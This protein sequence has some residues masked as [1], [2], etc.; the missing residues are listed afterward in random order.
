MRLG[1][2]IVALLG[3]VGCAAMHDAA[4]SDTE[5]FIDMD[6]PPGN[7]SAG[8][9][10]MPCPSP[11]DTGVPEGGACRESSDCA[12]GNAC[13]A[14]F[15]DG[16]AGE[17]TCTSQCVPLMDESSWCLDASACCDPGAV[18]SVRGLC[19]DGGLDDS[20]TGS[21]TGTGT[22]TTGDGSGT[23][24]SGTS[25]SGTAG[26]ESS[27]SDTGASTGTTGAG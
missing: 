23:S 18:C 27:G 6:T 25:G 13:T 22:G 4:V 9:G 17:F 3:L 2:T 14:P 12:S 7:C 20:G 16:Q 5:D 10:A 15:V 1:L 19:V 26:S 11:G 24:G 21:D 8:T